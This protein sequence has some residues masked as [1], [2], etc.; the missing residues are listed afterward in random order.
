MNQIHGIP[1]DSTEEQ[2]MICWFQELKANKLCDFERSPT[3]TLFNGLTVPAKNKAKQKTLLAEMVY[4]PDFNVHFDKRLLGAIT[5]TDGMKP[6]LIYVNSENKAVIEVKGTF[7]K[8][9]TDFEAPVKIKMLYSLHG[10]ITQIIKPYKLMA[11]TYFPKEMFYTEK[12][13]ERIKDGKKCK[14]KPYQK[15]AGK[16][17]LPCLSGNQS[18]PTDKG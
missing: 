17:G 14:E 8:Y 9:H 16:H 5:W 10:I 7:R 4:T 18:Q 11:K 13:K 2:D 6:G 12:G 1:Y 15:F 3:I